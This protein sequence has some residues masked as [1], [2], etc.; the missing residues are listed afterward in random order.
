MSPGHDKKYPFGIVLIYIDLN[1]IIAAACR[2]SA[3]SVLFVMWYALLILCYGY[4]SN[5]LDSTEFLI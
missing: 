4:L 5:F 1:G 2:Y 3:K